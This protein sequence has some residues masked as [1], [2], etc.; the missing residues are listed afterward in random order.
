M[1]RSSLGEGQQMSDHDAEVLWRSSERVYLV[2]T[3]KK[4]NKSDASLL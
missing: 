1:Y 3:Y 2:K 4:Y